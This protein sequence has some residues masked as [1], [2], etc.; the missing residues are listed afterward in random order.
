PTRTRSAIWPKPV[1]PRPLQ[2]T[3][4]RP[5]LPL[6]SPRQPLRLPKLLPSRKQRRRSQARPQAGRS[7]ELETFMKI[8][9][10]LAA[11]ICT[12]AVLPAMAAQPAPTAA[13]AGKAVFRAQCALCH[14]AE[15][16]DNGGA[17]GPSLSGLMRRAAGSAEGFSYTQAL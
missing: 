9:G 8:R 12:A 13:Q 7:A 14:S 6:R 4:A 17:Q 3:T 10:F 16:N 11:V 5:R 15:P 1:S 2:R